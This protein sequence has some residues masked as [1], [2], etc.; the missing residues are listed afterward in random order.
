M[1]HVK[2]FEDF[3]NGEIQ[4]KQPNF[5]FEWKEA[6]RYPEFKAIG[7]DGWIKIAQKGFVIKYSKIK[8]VLG[9]VDLNFDSLEN[10]KKNRFK[11]AIKTGEI[12]L[13]IVV[14]FSNQ[15]YDLVAGNTRLS[16]LVNMG[17]DPLVWVVNL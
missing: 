6:E 11:S 1:R 4:F 17:V 16:G 2:L 14:K 5:D 9:N 15:D 3:V 13:P 8:N 7:K 10:P 12:E